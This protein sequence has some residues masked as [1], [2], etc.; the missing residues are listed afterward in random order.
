MTICSAPGKIFLCGEHAVVYG[1][2]AIACAID[3]RT[4]VSIQ[5]SLD[6]SITSKLGRGIDRHPYVLKAI[7]RMKM[8]TEFDGVKVKIDSEIPPESGLGSSAAVTIATLSAINM[9]FDVGLSDEEIAELGHSIEVEIQGAASPTDTFIS[10]MGGVVLMPSRRRLKNLDYGFVVGDT[11]KTSSTKELVG[12]VSLL[13]ERYPDVVQMIFNAIG[14]IAKRGEHLI[15]EGDCSAIGE[16]MN[17]NQGLLESLGVGCPELSAQIYAARDAGAFG[18]KITGAGGGG[19]MVALVS[20]DHAEKV[21]KAIEE[22]GGR[23]IKARVTE[24][25]VATEDE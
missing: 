4:R 24:V 17:I 25:G 7:E 11:G 14:A 21:A 12:R 10:T 13:R 18:A 22:A 6:T 8:L 2:P 20:H 19:C 9:E 16:L 15:E 3:L 5:E 23:A 1:E